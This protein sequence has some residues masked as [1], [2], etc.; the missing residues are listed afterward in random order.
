MSSEII[1][2]DL[3]DNT[4][5]KFVT[6]NPTKQ[7]LAF[8]PKE[9]S[10]MFQGKSYDNTGNRQIGWEN[11][12]ATETVNND[13]MAF[14]N[15]IKV[16]DVDPFN[17]AGKSSYFETTKINFTGDPSNVNTLV[18]AYKYGMLNVNSSH[19]ETDYIGSTNINVPF[20]IN[21]TFANFKFVSENSNEFVELYADTDTSLKVVTLMNGVQRLRIPVN[22]F[23]TILTDSTAIEN[24][25]GDDIVK[26]YGKYFL[27]ITPKYIESQV[28]SIDKRQH[29]PYRFMNQ[30]ANDSSTYTD[31]E[32]HITPQNKRRNV[33][34][35]DKNN[36][37]NTIWNF[38]NN[39]RQS[40]RLYGSVVEVWDSTRTVLK[41]I[42][43]M[44]ENQFNFHDD[45]KN[46]ECVLQPDIFGYDVDSQDVSLGD[47]LRI[48][49]RESY[50]ND[51]FIDV[52]YKDEKL[53]LN[54]LISFLVNDTIRDM[55]TG[56][57]EI[58]DDKGFTIDTDG[59]FN[60]N[61]I[62]RYQ[63]FQKDKFEARKVLKS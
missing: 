27:A 21:E 56:I 41:Q 10:Q 38:E 19:T 23:N 4:V 13:T 8:F 34:K 5:E 55:T 16:T 57:F 7:Q 45:N 61:V 12:P 60:G 30:N 29:F 28:V 36:F 59:N 9:E 39:A 31:N 22:I 42:K 49:P 32:L 35:L 58:Y 24:N 1:K 53:E 63:I 47:I 50:F 51:L 3:F 46:F 44:T 33:Y 48:F 43:I 2:Y 15:D 11:N 52:N 54:S 26:N 17:S 25:G 20:L 6:I 40:G 62:K 37:L 14:M 18:Q